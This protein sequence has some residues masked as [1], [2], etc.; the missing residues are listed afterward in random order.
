MQTH[1]DDFLVKFLAFYRLSPV[2]LHHGVDVHLVLD[3]RVQVLKII[4]KIYLSSSEAC[5]SLL[6]QELF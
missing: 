3:A 2:T 5:S 6:V 1:H 4:L